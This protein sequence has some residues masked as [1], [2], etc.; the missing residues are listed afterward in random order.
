MA[1]TR[2]VRTPEQWPHNRFRKRPVEVLAMRVQK[3][4]LRLR[5]FA[6]EVTFVMESNGRSVAFL[7]VNTLEG[8]MRANVDDYLIRG[9]AGELYPCK[10]DIFEATYERVKTHR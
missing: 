9:V 6:P 5:E 8:K 7:L 1:D 2:T 10:A 3:P 4:W